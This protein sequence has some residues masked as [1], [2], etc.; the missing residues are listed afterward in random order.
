MRVKTLILLGAAVSGIAVMAGA[1]GA[2]ALDSILSKSSIRAYQTAVTY[3]FYH[4]L[5]LLILGALKSSSL[6]SS[7][8][9]SFWF[10][11]AS[12]LFVLGLVLFCGSLYVLALGGPRWFGPITPLGGLSFIVGWF[13]L[14]IYAYRLK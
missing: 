14:V 7:F 8:E 4:G 3:Q 10:N 12:R 1:F 6:E 13:C 9:N 11:Y 2:H 5:T